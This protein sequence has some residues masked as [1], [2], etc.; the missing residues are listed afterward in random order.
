[1][2]LCIIMEVWAPRERAYR[3][4]GRGPVPPYVARQVVLLEQQGA[5]Q[6]AEL[7][8]LQLT[9]DALRALVRTSTAA[10]R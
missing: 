7:H 10:T 6:A 5:N 1:M 8:R 2:Q 9:N 4:P 3:N